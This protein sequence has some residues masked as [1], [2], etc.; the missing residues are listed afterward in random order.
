LTSLYHTTA[1]TS[2]L[3]IT[4]TAWSEPPITPL[5]VRP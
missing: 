3:E 5:A 2:E 4:A 1:Q